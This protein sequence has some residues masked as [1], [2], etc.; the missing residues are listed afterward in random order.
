[1]CPR[2]PLA[3]LACRAPCRLMVSLSATLL[4]SGSAPA[5]SG[6]SLPRC[7]TPHLPLL[8]LQRLLPAQFLSLSGSEWQHSLQLDQP[9]PPVLGHQCKKHITHQCE[10][11]LLKGA[12]CLPGFVVMSGSEGC[13]DDL[14]WCLITLVWSHLSFLP[15]WVQ[16]SPAPLCSLET[17]LKLV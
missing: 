11:Q 2:V 10:M 5:C 1:M 16:V 13:R 17:L 15:A 9:L 4:C 14:F 12:F 8:N 3:L 7:R 6:L